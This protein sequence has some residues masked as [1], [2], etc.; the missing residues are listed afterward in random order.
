[1]ATNMMPHNLSE[2][3]DGCIAYIDNREITI[4]ELMQY[5]KAPDFQPVVLSTE[6]KASKRVF[7]LVGAV[8]V[9]GKLHVDTKPSG[10]EQIIIT[11]VP[12]Q[13]NRDALCNGS[14]NW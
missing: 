2:V 5:V 8:V 7:I 13:V 10:R 12:Y 1:M 3:V 4:D 14:D 9:R 11:E 6:W